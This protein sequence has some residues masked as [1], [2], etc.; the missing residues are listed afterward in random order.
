[1]RICPKCQSEGINKEFLCSFCGFEPEEINGFLAFSPELAEN[2]S[3]FD[4]ESFAGL[5]AAEGDHFWFR[6][7][8]E[9]ILWALDKY[10]PK[11]STLM[12]IGCGTGFVLN[13]IAERNPEIQLVGSEIFT[14]GL[15]FAARRLPRVE[16]FQMD[17][18]NLPYVEEFDVVG[19]FD[20]IEHIKE[21]ESVLHNIFRAVKPGGG[22]LV[23]VPQHKWLWSQIDV[24]ACHQRR[25]DAEE[26]R[27]KMIKAGFRL[28]RI[29][30]F[31][32]L[33]LPAMAMTRIFQKQSLGEQEKTADDLHISPFLN[34]IFHKFMMIESAII[35][36][37]VNFPMGGSLL[38]IGRKVDT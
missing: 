4:A 6:A 17:A 34:M 13:G 2:N 26:L 19:A 21:D 31:V 23:T 32:S 36:K 24:Q 11:A 29:T 10:F 35:K 18:R 37:E 28:E 20:V 14:A 8:N 27:E 12:E 25:Y 9:L 7:R 15:Q 22:C 1:M 33:L 3:G 5:A 30:S 38:M 16:L